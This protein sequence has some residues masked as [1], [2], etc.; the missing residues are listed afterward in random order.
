MNEKN[1]LDNSLILNTIESLKKHFFEV[2]FC[3]NKD[4]A[5]NEL[6]NI[7]KKDSIIGYGGSKT[8]EEIGF[9]E[10]FTTKDYPNIIDRKNPNNTPEIKR[11]LQN[12]AL[13][14][15]F[16]L[17]SANAVSQT[18]ELILIDK[19]GNR[20][21]GMTFGPK[22]RI[23]V[24]G[25]NKIESD[26]HKALNRAK[27]TASVLNN[28]RFETKN[29][30]TTAGKCMDCNTL[31]RLCSVTTIIHRNQ[32]PKSIMIILINEELGF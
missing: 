8:L 27:N 31:E 28:K 4:E 22:K 9:F 12:K 5:L 11:E 16:F 26:L 13:T 17:C 21:A 6:Q 3:N 10:K 30:C 14:S 24:I 18:G 32:P 1:Q 29:P 7:I 19:W 2:I 20:N 25:K 23:F 15:D